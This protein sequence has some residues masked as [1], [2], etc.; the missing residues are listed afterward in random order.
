MMAAHLSDNDMALACFRR[1]AALVASLKHAHIVTFHEVAV[2][3]ML[4]PCWCVYKNVM[5]D[6]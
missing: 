2:K 6:L 1:E 4:R 5:R 3:T